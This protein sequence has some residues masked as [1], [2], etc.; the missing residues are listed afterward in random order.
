ML[1]SIVINPTFEAEF[2]AAFEDY[3]AIQPLLAAELVTTT[4]GLI[5]H[6]SKNPMLYQKVHKKFRQRM[7]GKFPYLLILLCQ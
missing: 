4:F 7:C 3:S 1:Y 6:I 5:E 2:D